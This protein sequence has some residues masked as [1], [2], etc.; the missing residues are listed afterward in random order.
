M[1]DVETVATD[2]DLCAYTLGRSSLNDLIP[3]DEAWLAS[4]GVSKSA[5]VARRT[6]L[7]NV[8]AALLRRRPVISEADLIDPSELRQVVCYGA[9]E[10]LYRGAIQH[11]ESPNVGRAKS[12]AALYASELQSMQPSVRAGATTSS[13]S[14]RLSRG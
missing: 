5:A 10:I 7:A 2:A 11:E 13:L 1:I 14:V 8:L 9:L 4:D 6:A 3:D 12:F